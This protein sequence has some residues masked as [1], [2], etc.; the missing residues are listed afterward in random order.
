MGQARALYNYGNVYHAKG[1]NICW[2][3]TDPGEL[4]EEARVALKKA[5]EYYE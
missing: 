3:G 2:S 1:K 4:P 5:T